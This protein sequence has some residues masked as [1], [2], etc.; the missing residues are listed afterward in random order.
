MTPNF[1]H[2]LPGS[3]RRRREPAR[4]RGH[5][6]TCPSPFPLFFLFQ[7]DVN[8]LHCENPTVTPK[9]PLQGASFKKTKVCC[10]KGEEALLVSLRGGSKADCGHSPGF[11]TC[12]RCQAAPL[13]PTAGFWC[14]PGAVALAVPGPRTLSPPRLARAALVPPGPRTRSPRVRRR[15]SPA[16]ATHFCLGAK[17]AISVREHFLQKDVE[18][19]CV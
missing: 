2:R 17:S 18:I 11:R 4:A 10:C 5:H 7:F 8:D 14:F 6:L 12:G 3:V 1:P 15:L 16:V 19:H 9:L 13:S